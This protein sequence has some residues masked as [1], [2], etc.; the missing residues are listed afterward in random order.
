M[1][2]PANDEARVFLIEP[3]KVIGYHGTSSESAAKI[4]TDGFRA[5]TQDWEWLGRGAYFWQDAPYRAQSWAIERLG[6]EGYTGPIAVVAAEI[7][8]AGFTDLLDKQGMGQLKEIAERYVASNQ[9]LQN[10]GKANRLDCAV[11]N[12]A[13][14][15]LQSKGVVVNGYRAACVEGLPL[16]PGSPVHDLSHVQIVV[17]DESAILRKWMVETDEK[18]L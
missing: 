12:F 1:R 16:T 5:S 3:I 14:I 13:T 17:I 18:E 4:L 9:S 7:L 11:F 6:R 10:A 8:L 15:V 2:G